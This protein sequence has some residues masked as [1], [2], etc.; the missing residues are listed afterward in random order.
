MIV[1]S[2]A[3]GNHKP[4]ASLRDLQ[5]AEQ[6]AKIQGCDVYSIPADFD[7]CEN[8]ENALFH[9]PMQSE[10]KSAAWIGYIPSRDRYAGIYQA[11]LQKNIRLLNAPDE[12]ARALEFDKMY[13]LLEG[14]TPKSVVVEKQDELSKSAETIGFPIFLKGS[15]Q[16]R[17]SKGL[18]AC[19][20]ENI[21]ELE[22]AAKHLFELEN[23]T[24]GKVILRQ[25]REL[26]HVRRIGD[27]PQGRE[28]RVFL[29]RH[30]VLEYGYYWDEKDE[31]SDLSSEEEREVLSLAIEASSR[32]NVPFLCVDVGQLA[33]GSWIVIETGDPQFSGMSKISP[34]KLWKKLREIGNE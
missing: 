17:K 12:H 7:I 21:E 19:F 23:R 22:I 14:I 16:S 1:L 28:F 30:E 15:V 3:H 27:F 10:M 11:A 2:E 24:R 6:A 34:L 29:Y 4:S 5:T 32:M 33:D 8:A 18:R 9:I 25:F 31:L 13:P 26:R 20:A